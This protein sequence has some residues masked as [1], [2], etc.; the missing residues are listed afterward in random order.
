MIRRGG[1]GSQQSQSQASSAGGVRD[2]SSEAF[3]P[4]FNSHPPTAGGCS[5]PRIKFWMLLSR[6]AT[7]LF[8]FDLG[9]QEIFGPLEQTP[10]SIIWPVRRTTAHPFPSIL[11]SSCIDE[12]LSALAAIFTLP[13][14][15]C[16]PSLGFV[17][18]CPKPAILVG[19]SVEPASDKLHAGMA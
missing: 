4:D 11:R 3:A 6:L 9:N 18:G 1:G 7:D 19:S 2:R 17:P 8:H 5:L 14:S 12:L 16:Y 15:R 10:M 13:A